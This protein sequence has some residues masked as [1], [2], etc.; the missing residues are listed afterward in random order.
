MSKLHLIVSLV[1]LPVLSWNVS[2]ED[3]KSRIK[4]PITVTSDSLTADNKA[5]TALFDK[6]VVATM[7]DMTIHADSMRVHYKE[8]G[9]DVTRLEA[10]GNVRVYR[11]GR[12]I[13][14]KEAVYHAD[15][16]KVIFNGNPRAIDGDNIV[17]GTRITYFIKED[18]TLVD[19]STVIL[20]SRQDK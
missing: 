8:Q 12:L 19:N 4:G 11:D 5:H 7:T 17:S 6:N 9:G 20:K 16:E 18:R 1:L 3:I 10:K 14:S 15:E 2:A 13:T